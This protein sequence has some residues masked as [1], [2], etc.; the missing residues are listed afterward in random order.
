[1]MYTVYNRRYTG[2]YVEGVYTEFYS[3]GR[4]P[5]GSGHMSV[6]SMYTGK[7]KGYTEC[8][9][10][11]IC[12][13]FVYLVNNDP[14]FSASAGMKFVFRTLSD[15]VFRNTNLRLN[16]IFYRFLPCY[17]FYLQLKT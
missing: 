5:S 13:D 14:W 2:R 1:M 7:I 16:T 4:V 6:Y 8:G 9:V 15:R 12:T 3:C 17:F 11:G 10:E